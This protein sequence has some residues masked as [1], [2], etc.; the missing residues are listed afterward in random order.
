[1]ICFLTWLALIGIVYAYFGYPLILLAAK[2]LGFGTGAD[3][4]DGNYQPV[5]YTH[6]TLPTKA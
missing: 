6:L 3:T 2:K 5:S 4:F 1:M